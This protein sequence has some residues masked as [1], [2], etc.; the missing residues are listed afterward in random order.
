MRHG[1]PAHGASCIAVFLERLLHRFGPQF[2]RFDICNAAN[3][4]SHTGECSRAV[5]PLGQHRLFVQALE[6]LHAPVP[7]PTMLDVPAAEMPRRLPS[8]SA[9][10][11]GA[12]GPRPTAAAA[13][14]PLLPRLQADSL[15]TFLEAFAGFGFRDPGAAAGLERR[16]FSN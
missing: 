9:I 15:K 12:A 3:A 5:Y 2:S 8:S 7:L 16:A 10:G 14:R 11:T 6:G 4:T 1:V 13:A